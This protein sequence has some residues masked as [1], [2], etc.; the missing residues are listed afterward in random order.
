MAAMGGKELAVDGV[1]GSKVRTMGLTVGV[2]RWA[3]SESVSRCR[4]AA[5]GGSLGTGGLT[6]EVEEEEQE[7]AGEGL[8]PFCR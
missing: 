8:A 1:A 6:G 3:S 7:E 2:G 4:M 5:G